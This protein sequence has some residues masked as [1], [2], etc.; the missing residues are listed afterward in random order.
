L[1]A[2]ASSV[3]PPAGSLILY[4][5]WLKND[6]ETVA[7][8]LAF[9]ADLRRRDPQWGL[10]RVEDFEEAAAAA[11]DLSETRSMPA[12]NLMLRFVRRGPS[13]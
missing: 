11:F 8:N 3:L 10:R 6:I 4:G 5:P 2:G 1:I 9:D 12:N 7:S 13:T